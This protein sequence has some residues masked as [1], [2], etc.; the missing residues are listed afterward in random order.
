MSMSI[1]TLR[2]KILSGQLTAEHVTGR[3]LENIRK[4]ADVNAFINVFDEDALEEARNIDKK[5]AAGESVGR[6]PAYR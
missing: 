2:N 1:Y 4:N 6:L 5:I 3:A